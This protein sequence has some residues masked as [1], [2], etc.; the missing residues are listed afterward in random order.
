MDS[1][2]ASS[3]RRT[4]VSTGGRGGPILIVHSSDDMYGADKM[5][6]EVIDALPV[7]DRAR[8]V[9]WLPTDYAHG[10]TPLCRR[11]SDAGVTCE[12]VALPILRRRYLN[13]AGLLGMATRA[14]RVR[15]RAAQLEPQEIILATSA[16]LP[17]APLLRRPPGGRI[18][19]H[20]QEVWQGREATGLGVLAA[21]V[22]RIVAISEASRASLPRRL[23]SRSVV[24]PNGTPAPDSVQPL[25]QH[26]GELV[27]VVAS[28]WNAWKGH[29][30]LLEAWDT[31]GCP[32]RLVILGGPPSMGA[33][34]DVPAL[35][36]RCRRP[37]TIDVLGEVED[38]AAILDDA[39][40][41]L[42]PSTQ[43]EPFGLVTIE[44]FA[45]GRPVVASAHGGLL[46]TVR[47]G[48]GWLVEPGDVKAWAERLGSLTREQVVE[49]GGRARERYERLYSRAAF[50]AGLREALR[51][52]DRGGETPH[53]P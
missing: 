48:A 36:R 49:A 28:R 11:L 26:S 47:D 17:L 50:Q 4:A 7:A 5:V 20:L 8:V 22:D 52:D 3:G 35:V 6:L 9:V 32:G 19:L 42:V 23:R 34:V 27:F 2:G 53:A 18:V 24:V 43:P 13:P 39:D 25:S 46:E 14:A 21:R 45:R 12:H 29:E 1:A 31:A 51:W 30:L 33:G 16:A 38:V 37:E 44:A 40:V 41:M 10:A 15:A